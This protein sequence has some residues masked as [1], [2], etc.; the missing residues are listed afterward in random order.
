MGM[1]R[2]ETYHCGGYLIDGLWNRGMIEQMLH[3]GA[4]IILFT[5]PQGRKISIH[6]IESGIERYEIRKTLAAN[7]EKGIYTLFM[8]W[9][10]MMVPNQNRLFEMTDWMEAFVALNGG[11]VYAYDILYGEVYLFPVYFRDMGDQSIFMTEYGLTLDIS[12]LTTRTVETHIPGFEDTWMVADFLGTA[13]TAE[14]YRENVQPPPPPVVEVE[15]TEI[16]ILY[17]T[18]GVKPG[19]DRETIKQAYRTLARRYHPDTNPDE[20]ANEQM[21]KLNEAYDR[22]IELLEE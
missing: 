16:E 5:T 19:D 14:D 10:T 15:L 21:R 18:L 8:L 20:D 13:E 2:S 4:D 6:L 1:I 11:C 9:A 17:T 12:Q 3:D 7:A 22:L